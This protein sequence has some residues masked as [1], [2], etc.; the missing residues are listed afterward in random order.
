MKTCLFVC[1]FTFSKKIPFTFNAGTELTL[2][3]TNRTTKTGLRRRYM[4]CCGV[5]HSRRQSKDTLDMLFLCTHF[6][7]VNAALQL[8][9]TL[10]IC[11][12]GQHCQFDKGGVLYNTFIIHWE[13][14]RHGKWSVIVNLGLYFKIPLC[15]AASY[16]SHAYISNW[17][18]MDMRI[19]LMAATT[20]LLFMMSVLNPI[21]FFS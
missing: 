2:K 14:N 1:V 5:R 16:N 6:K 8:C 18:R 21:D 19:R 3:H 17:L 12:S 9:R 20:S 11:V 13:K 7:G 4:S 15:P 10:Q